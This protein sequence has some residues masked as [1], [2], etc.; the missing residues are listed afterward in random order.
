MELRDAS[1]VP[2]MNATGLG[3]RDYASTL[4]VLNSAGI[5]RILLHGQVSP[6]SMR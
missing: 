2:M 4:W 5:R 6:G 1:F 3:H